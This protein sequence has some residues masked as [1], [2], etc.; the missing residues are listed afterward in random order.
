MKPLDLAVAIFVITIWG[1]NFVVVKL[2]LEEMP[3]FLFMMLRFA[4]VAAILVPFVRWPKG[5][6]W[7]LLAYATVLGTIHF[8]LMFNAI[9]HI[10]ASTVALLSQLN[11]PFAVLISALF[12]RDYPGWRR[13]LGIVI[14]FAGC[15]IIAGEPRFDDDIAAILMVVG[16]TLAWAVAAA[17]VKWIGEIN[18]FAL[19]GWMALMAAPQLALITYIAEDGQWQALSEV[20]IQGVG[21]VLYQSVMV[22]IVGYGLWYGLIKRYPL[23]RVIPLTLLLPLIGV[24]GGT[25]L[26][27]EALTWAMIW[28][29]LLIVIGVGIVVLRQA[30]RGEAPDPKSAR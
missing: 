24:A 5:K 1:L 2:G 6:F 19:N 28:G 15:A 25:T 29:G 17:Q 11:T 7:P 12:F 16:G 18:P 27:G 23:S 20:S 8:S 10:D 14:A 26:L 3:P 22:V 4:V 30:Q 9:N 13:I 21:A